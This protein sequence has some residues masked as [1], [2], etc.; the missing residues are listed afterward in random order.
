[1]VPAGN[2][3][4][5][6]GKRGPRDMGCRRKQATGDWGGGREEPGTARTELH[7]GSTTRATRSQC[8]VPILREAGGGLAATAVTLPRV[9]SQRNAAPAGGAPGPPE[10]EWPLVVEREEEGQG[11]ERERGEIPLQHPFAPPGTGAG[12][13]RGWVQGE[14]DG[15]RGGGGVLGHGRGAGLVTGTG[16]MRA[17]LSARYV[18]LSTLEDLSPKMLHKK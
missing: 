9:P 13:N 3:G 1:M 17:K 10:G 7:A 5:G 18:C 14:I 6:E 4:E 12:T 2:E 16:R 8:V 15:W 11:R